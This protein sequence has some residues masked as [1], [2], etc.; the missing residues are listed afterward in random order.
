MNSVYQKL[1]MYCLNKGKRKTKIIINVVST[2]NIND[3]GKK[4]KYQTK[5]NFF[6]VYYFQ[7]INSNP[8]LVL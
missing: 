7:K 8:M 4:G 3:R 1:F 2:F 5:Y 6:S